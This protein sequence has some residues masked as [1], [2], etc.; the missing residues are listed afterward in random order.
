MVARRL[1]ASLSDGSEPSDTR[2]I[3]ADCAGLVM[4]LAQLI[5]SLSFSSSSA[6]R[7]LAAP[8][9]HSVP[10]RNVARCR[11][12]LCH[13]SDVSNDIE[14]LASGHGFS[15]VLVHPLALLLKTSSSLA[16]FT[17]PLVPRNLE[18]FPGKDLP[19]FGAR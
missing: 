5:H 17:L 16:L 9:R 6:S 13:R 2:L 8:S 7:Q 11:S 19:T 18:R 3:T 15:D 4:Y 14:V 12:V 1:R 10:N